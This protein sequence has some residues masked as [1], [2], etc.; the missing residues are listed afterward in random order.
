M[1]ATPPADP[2][3]PPA[4]AAPRALVVE[5]AAH[6]RQVLALLAARRGFEVLE[7]ASG[8]AAL[9]L[10]RRA[11]PS[12][13]LLEPALPDMEGVALLEA[14]RAEHPGLPVVIV[15]S[16]PRRAEVQRL[17]DLGATALLRKPFDT[18]EVEFLLD[19]LWHGI[20]EEG[21]A[22]AAHGL[23]Q[24]RSTRLDVPSHPA[25]LA[26]VV[27]WLGRDL[28]QA[29][30]GRTLPLDEV[31][32]ALYEALAN[33]IEHGNLGISGSMKAEALERPGGL[34]ALMRERLADPQLAA[35]RIL[36][37]VTYQPGAVEWCV[38][39]EG[40]GFDPSALPALALGNVQALHGRGLALVRHFM[41]AVHWNACG[42][43]IRMLRRLDEAGVPA[44][45]GA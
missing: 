19:R 26:R 5:P 32:L 22:R 42:N 37:Q 25:M 7:A 2:L 14:L 6:V 33:A 10:A 43:E 27:A 24:E 41:S 8:Q 20:A 18:A 35:R 39:D 40:Q 13:V 36:V 44:A 3:P 21:E 23:V 17:L 45:P 38:R 1:S 9:A 28:R 12:V 16:V 15:G 31:K 4:P 29:Y 30:P 11:E 34:D